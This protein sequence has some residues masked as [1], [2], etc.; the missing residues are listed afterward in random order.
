MGG[1]DRWRALFPG[2]IFDGVSDQGTDRALVDLGIVIL[3]CILTPINPGVLEFFIY[4]AALAG[5]RFEVKTAT[6]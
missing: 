6:P 2:A 5:F 1:H 3:A 4:A